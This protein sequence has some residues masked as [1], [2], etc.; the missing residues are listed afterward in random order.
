MK[1]ISTIFLIMGSSK[2][3]ICSLDVALDPIVAPG[4]NNLFLLGDK[5]GPVLLLF[6]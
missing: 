1:S 4:P 6:L 3:Y 5:G 2:L